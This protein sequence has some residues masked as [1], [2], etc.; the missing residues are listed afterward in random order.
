MKLT[1]GI[2]SSLLKD[3][4]FAAFRSEMNGRTVSHPPEGTGDDFSGFQKREARKCIPELLSRA[5]AY[6]WI[7]PAEKTISLNGEFEAGARRIRDD[8]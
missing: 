3:R 4:V 1:R 6:I 2:A 8:V 7:H 5:F